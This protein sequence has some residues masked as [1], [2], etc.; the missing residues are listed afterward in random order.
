MCGV[1]FDQ[2]PCNYTVLFV[3]RVHIKGANLVFLNSIAEQVEWEHRIFY[4]LWHIDFLWDL[5]TSVLDVDTDADF[6]DFRR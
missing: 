1:N 5:R 4:G 2:I 6:A 3:L